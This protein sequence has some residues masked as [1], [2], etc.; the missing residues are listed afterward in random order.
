MKVV[1]LTKTVTDYGHSYEKLAKEFRKVYDRGKCVKL[2]LTSVNW[3]G[4]NNVLSIYKIM[5]KEK[6]VEEEEETASE[7]AR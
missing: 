2:S 6:G 7:D 3:L 5:T 1:R 4:R